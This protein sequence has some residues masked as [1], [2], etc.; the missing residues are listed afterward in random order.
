MAIVPHKSRHIS[1][2]DKDRS[3]ATKCQIAS[4]GD[5]MFSKGIAVLYILKSII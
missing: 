1:I 3:D 2:I 4:R 5:P